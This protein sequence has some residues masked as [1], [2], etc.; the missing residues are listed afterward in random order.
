MYKLHKSNTTN[1]TTFQN[2][3]N[4]TTLEKQVIEFIY[5]G[6]KLFSLK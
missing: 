2:K 6:I 4:K 1:Y 3:Y 5:H